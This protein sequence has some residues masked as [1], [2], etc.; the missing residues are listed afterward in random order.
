MGKI[1]VWRYCRKKINERGNIF[2]CRNLLWILSKFQQTENFS[3]DEISKPSSRVPTAKAITLRVR[4][5][6]GQH[7]IIRMR[8]TETISTLRN[9]IQDEIKHSNFRILT[10][11]DSGWKPIEDEGQ[12][13][14]DIGLGPRAALQLA[15]MSHRYEEMQQHIGTG[16]YSSK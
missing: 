7:H 4:N 14:Y 5:F 13:L 9:Y 2:M 8:A 10:L 16:P 11:K 12:T 6:D 15:P 1:F 3:L